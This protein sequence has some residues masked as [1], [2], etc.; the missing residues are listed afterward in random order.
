MIDPNESRYLESFC[1]LMIARYGQDDGITV[2]SFIKK[3][4]GEHLLN[5]ICLSKLANSTI[6]IVTFTSSEKMNKEIKDY[7][8][9]SAACFESR[10]W[11][12]RAKFEE[13]LDNAIKQ[14]KE[15]K[16]Y[17]I[18]EFRAMRLIRHL[19]TQCNINSTLS[20]I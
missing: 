11:Q 16:V 7:V 20:A 3:Q 8:V 6:S 1:N 17:C 14:H 2:F 9:R 18:D 19:K 15:I 4:F 5:E 12:W 10:Y 13:E